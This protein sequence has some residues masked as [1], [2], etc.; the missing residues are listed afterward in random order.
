MPKVSTKGQ[1]FQRWSTKGKK[2]GELAPGSLDAHSSKM[3]K[4]L[5][6]EATEKVMTAQPEPVNGGKKKR[7][8]PAQRRSPTPKDIEDIKKRKL[9]A[10]TQIKELTKE[11]MEGRLAWVSEHEEGL[12]Q[13][14]EKFRQI[15]LAIPE[16]YGLYYPHKNE[17]L[18]TALRK[19]VAEG[20]EEL[21]LDDSTV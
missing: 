10:E 21:E 19:L 18:T 12:V 5:T 16:K 14:L 2:I 11:L 7:N 3:V 13:L 20:I 15:L 6:A 9:W 17:A 4:E 8:Y 1:A